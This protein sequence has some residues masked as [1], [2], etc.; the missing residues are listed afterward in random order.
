MWLNETPRLKY[1]ITSFLMNLNVLRSNLLLAATIASIHRQSQHLIRPIEHTSEPCREVRNTVDKIN[2]RKRT[3]QLPRRVFEVPSPAEYQ[4]YECPP[5]GFHPQVALRYDLLPP[6]RCQPCE[7][8]RI[9]FVMPYCSAQSQKLEECQFISMRHAPVDPPYEPLHRTAGECWRD[10]NL[11]FS[12]SSLNVGLDKL[13][14]SAR[15]AEKMSNIYYL[16]P[17]AVDT[18]D[19]DAV[20]FPAH[21][22]VDG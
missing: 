22:C 9:A 11:G 12:L 13:I 20:L 6:N 7:K 1:F 18:I 4:C 10:R 2:Y 14:K 8:P 17:R 16:L 21:D 19:H 5:R 3:D 15:I